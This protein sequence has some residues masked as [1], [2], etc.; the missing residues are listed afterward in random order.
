MSIKGETKKFH[1]RHHR[2]DKTQYHP[3]LTLPPLSSS[4]CADSAVLR[5]SV[6]FLTLLH[7]R[8]LSPSHFI[9]FIRSLNFH[10]RKES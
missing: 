2:N 10:L 1:F 8:I 6:L 3:H 9:A 7:V 5:K 4:M